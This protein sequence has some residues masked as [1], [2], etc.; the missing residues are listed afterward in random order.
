[1]HLCG[2]PYVRLHI[3]L[4]FFFSKFRLDISFDILNVR[5]WKKHNFSMF[6]H[7]DSFY[8]SNFYIWL[9]LYIIHSLRLYKFAIN[10]LRHWNCS[11]NRRSCMFTTLQMENSTKSKKKTKKKRLYECVLC[12]C[13]RYKYNLGYLVFEWNVIHPIVIS[14]VMLR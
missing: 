7:F 6:T 13:T 4:F 1:M 9:F 12:V 11:T 3:A 5:A 10:V 2:R 8:H 14:K